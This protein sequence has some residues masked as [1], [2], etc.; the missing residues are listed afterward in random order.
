[1]KRF[2]ILIVKVYQRL[3]SPMLV[4]LFGRGCRFTPTCSDYTIE[5][6]EKFGLQRGGILAVKRILRCHP[7]SSGWF[8]P[9]P[10]EY[11]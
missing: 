2:A 10:N 11:F 9:I 4:V 6:I 7:F 3:F 1:M 8:D 5:A